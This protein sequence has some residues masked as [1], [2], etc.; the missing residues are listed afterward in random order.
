MK[1]LL[2]IAALVA[3]T[4]YL[5]L[6]VSY[7]ATPW[8]IHD[9]ESYADAVASFGPPDE[10]LTGL[11]TAAVWHRRVYRPEIIARIHDGRI[12]MHTVDGRVCLTP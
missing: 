8:R 12:L 6:I 1:R 9:G 3:A 7:A 11:D 10:T 2:L 4:A 5:G